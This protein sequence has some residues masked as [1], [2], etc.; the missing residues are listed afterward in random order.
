M[1]K[2][3]LM[4]ILGLFFMTNAFSAESPCGEGGCLVRSAVDWK[5]F[6][7]RNNDTLIGTV[8]TPAQA[9][10]SKTSLPIADSDFPIYAKS[11][12]KS[13]RTIKDTCPG[14]I[15]PLIITDPHCYVIWWVYSDGNLY[16]TTRWPCAWGNKPIHPP[17]TAPHPK[18]EVKKPPP[19]ASK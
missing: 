1:K 17:V 2:I 7:F 6:I 3:L 10:S 9:G 15:R 19:K 11:C 8:K 14:D 13:G 5:M 4:P 16:Y 18:E 12:S